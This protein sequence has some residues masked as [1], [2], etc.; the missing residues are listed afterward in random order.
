MSDEQAPDWLPPAAV[1]IRGGK[2]KRGPMEARV[3]KDHEKLGMYALSCCCSSSVYDRDE[4]ARIAQM[5]H[6]E[7]RASTVER[8]RAAGFEISATPTHNNPTH[9]TLRLPE[10]LRDED[11]DALEAAFDDPVPNVAT[12]EGGE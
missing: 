8:I 4:L 6:R 11:W 3:R 5:P 2:M 10:P 12:L 7:L 9:A 1:V